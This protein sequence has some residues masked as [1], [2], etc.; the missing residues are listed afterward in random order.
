[1]KGKIETMEKQLNSYVF[2]VEKEVNGKKYNNLYLS[3]GNGLLTLPINVKIF[4][5]NGKKDF[6]DYDKL[7]N[8]LKKDV[9]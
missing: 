1:M 9:K 2:L 6:H 7:I 5:S 3:V 8:W 4:E